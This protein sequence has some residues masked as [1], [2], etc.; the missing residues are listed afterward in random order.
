MRLG[1]GLGGYRMSDCENCANFKPVPKDDSLKSL[2][3]FL[4]HIRSDDARVVIEH[5]HKWKHRLTVL[6]DCAKYTYYI[7]CEWE[8]KNVKP[9]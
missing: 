3:D 1:A 9:Y 6:S 8:G 2:K 5:D 4:G 7:D